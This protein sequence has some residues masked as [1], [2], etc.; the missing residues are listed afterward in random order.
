MAATTGTLAPLLASTTGALLII[1]SFDHLRLRGGTDE[2]EAYAAAWATWGRRPLDRVAR[3][4]ADVPHATPALIVLPALPSE[5][6]GDWRG[7]EAV[8]IQLLAHTRR[9]GFAEIDAE[10]GSFTRRAV[11]EG[12]VRFPL[13]DLLDGNAQTLP[14]YDPILALATTTANDASA[15]TIY[16][17]TDKD[18]AATSKGTVTVRL[19]RRLWPPVP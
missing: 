17:L 1:E 16:S 11:Q 12:V 7:D 15:R 18:L 14:F 6:S 2:F 3:R 13:R 19:V 5:T 10:E 9:S 4:I 8:W